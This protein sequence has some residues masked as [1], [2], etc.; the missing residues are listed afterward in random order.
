MKIAGIIAEYNPFHNG[1]ATHI[2][3]TRDPSGGRA[4]HVVAV[5]S[6]SFVQRGEPALYPKTDRV[7][8]ALA[9]GVDLVVELPVP[10]VLTSAEGFAFGGVALLEAL[11]CVEQISFG[12]ECGDVDA[13]QR[14]A[15]CMNTDDYWEQVKQCMACG[16]TAAAAQQTALA[17][18]TDTKTAAL[19][20]QPNNTLAVEYLR[21]LQRLHSPISPFTVPRTGA[22]HN[23]ELPTGTT[24]SASFLRRLVRE[25]R[26]NNTAPYMPQPAFETLANA[27]NAGHAPSDPALLERAVLL[28]LRQLSPQKLH[29]VAGFSEGLENRL[30]RVAEKACALTELSELTKTKRYPL[31]RIQRAVWAAMLDIPAGLCKEIPPYI[32]VLGMNERGREILSVARK[33][34]TLPLFVNTEQANAFTDKAA[35]VWRLECRAT[36]WFNLSL[37]HPRPHGTD[38]TDGM[39][40][41][42]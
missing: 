18:R 20:E 4:T 25:G 7:R 28:K 5:M 13:L 40:R 23:D 38:F 34:A 11:G 15:A 2:L 21:A 37:P 19:L 33:K 12:S 1:H 31:T 39:V 26:W 10:W 27:L 16:D 17:F 32:R 42:E 29:T 36:E 22:G 6:G 41:M 8:A 35:A 30:L 24:A 3:R 14:V 9:G